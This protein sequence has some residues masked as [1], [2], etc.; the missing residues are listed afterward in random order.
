MRHLKLL[1][2]LAI[3]MAALGI[4]VTYAQTIIRARAEGSYRRGV[5]YR[6]H[7]MAN[8]EAVSG[9]DRVVLVGTVESAV[10]NDKSEI[11]NFSMKLRSGQRRTV[12]LSTSLYPQLPIE[13]EQGLSKLLTEG[14][15]VRVVAYSCPGAAAVLE[16]DEIRAL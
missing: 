4:S 16:A 1:V 14:K 7:K 13:A 11:V 5:M 2:L 12:N 8:P 3:V 15:R 9:C 6:L 10:H